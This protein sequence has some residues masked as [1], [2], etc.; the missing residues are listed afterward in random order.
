[1]SIRICV[2]IRGGNVETVV[3]D[4]EEVEVTVFDY[5]TDGVEES[6]IEVDPDGNRCFAFEK[7]GEYDP[8]MVEHFLGPSEKHVVKIRFGSNDVP[9]EDR[10]VSNYEFSTEQAYLDGVRDMDGWLDYDDNPDEDEDDDGEKEDAEDDGCIDCAVC[11][12]RTSMLT[13]HLHQG[14]WIGDDCCWDERLRA[15]E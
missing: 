12:K 2:F 3:F 13:A 1:M 6:R 14:V 10:P 4:H 9:K 5:D 7:A 8:Q 15:S 11:G